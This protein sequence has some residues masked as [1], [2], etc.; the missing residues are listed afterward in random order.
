MTQTK[1]REE[2]LKA[3]KTIADIAS[4][5]GVSWSLYQAIESGRLK[6]TI[7]VRQR[8]ADLF[9]V[10]FAE[11]WP[12]TVAEVAELMATIKADAKA[13]RSRKAAK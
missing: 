5:V 10:P 4:A 2:R 12:D 3:G 9:H 11:M 7:A 13:G 6:G 1:L 8:L